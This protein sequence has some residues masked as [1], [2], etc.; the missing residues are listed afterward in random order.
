MIK[1]KILLLLL[2][3]SFCWG[4]YS[5]NE[6]KPYVFTTPGM[7]YLNDAI[8]IKYSSRKDNN[9]HYNYSNS[10]RSRIEHD[11]LYTARRKVTE[12]LR[13]EKRADFSI[14]SRFNKES[15]IAEA[16]ANSRTGIISGLDWWSLSDDDKRFYRE[17][18]INYYQGDPEVKRLNERLE[19]ELSKAWIKSSTGQRSG[20]L[21]SQLPSAD[22][23]YY[24]NNYMARKENGLLP[25]N[26]S[27][28][29]AQAEYKEAWFILRRHGSV[30][31][32]W[33]QLTSIEK[34]QFRKDYSVMAAHESGMLA[35]R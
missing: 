29:I 9:P 17:R 26:D 3:C 25:N 24:K 28:M 31:K 18:Y 7:Q 8:H 19:S 5:E 4:N 10:V 30:N 22:K 23:E 32:T 6:E 33:N 13:Q 35:L 11:L 2:S 16:W 34:S 20:K 1:N 12:H 27:M 14:S 21:W 15:L